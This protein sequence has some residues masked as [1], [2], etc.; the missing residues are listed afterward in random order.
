MTSLVH[1]ENRRASASVA[2][3]N[4]P[5]QRLGERLVSAGILTSD[6][7]ESALQQQSVNGQRVG[8]TL[9]ELGFIEEEQLLPYLAEQL[10]IPHVT[11]RDGLIDP[12]S[13]LTIPRRKAEE[14]EAI[15]LF[16]VRDVLTV[17]MRN[18]QQLDYID[19]I[20][21]LTKCRV[22]P[23]L[24]MKSAIEQLLPRCYDE[25]FEV[26]A[27][28]AD[29]DQE[30]ISVQ[31]DAIHVQLQSVESI[32]DGSPIVNLVNY[33]I[34]QAARQGASD[35]HIEPGANQ[36]TVRFRVDGM[37]REVLRPRRE[38]HPAIVSRIKVMAKMDIAEHRMPQDGRIHVV[39][40]RRDIDLRCS[41]L[42]TVQGEKV[43]LR[44]LDRSSVT[45]NL[46]ELGIPNNQLK[47]MKEILAKPYGLALVTGPTGSGKTTTLYS[48]IEL[49]KNV[50]RNIV[51]VEDPVEYQL[52]LINQ[53][54]ANAGTS[55]SFAKVLR[56][57]LRQ[58]PDVIMIGEIR[59]GETAEVAI[60][61]AL[62]GHLVLSTLH[63]NDSAGAIT[64]LMD[65]GIASYKTAA[66][67]V[68]AIAQR[69]VRRVCQNCRTTY[70]PQAQ[71]LE[72]L[73]YKG[74]KKQQFIRGEG[75]HECYDTGFKGRIGIYEILHADNELRELIGA[76]ASVDKIR[77]WHRTHGGTSLLQEGLRLAQEGITSLD[78]IMRVA[79]FE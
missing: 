8:E 5:R 18:P 45:F 38:F 62:T 10:N 13:V 33:M 35:I 48:A 75:C 63:T 53:V 3:R 30:A 49:I 57:I 44:V 31:D 15:V 19:E 77:Q 12:R 51:T 6:E 60:Q 7:L 14:F 54:H 32:G 58:D 66:A 36:S 21:R 2:Q 72:T 29:M 50:N 17:A 27:V 46:N 40:D 42:P 65:M 9:V 59:D 39:V 61:A 76:D 55:L 20:E 52:S 71:M 24:A 41:T 4:K 28:T 78:E 1:S 68:G 69:L 47:S 43:V 74:D 56:A 11:L 34:L 64:R 37:L 16:K 22:R 26:D 79:Y 67:F 25:G 70:Y 23:V 73:H